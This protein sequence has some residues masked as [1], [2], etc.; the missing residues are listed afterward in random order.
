MTDDRRRSGRARSAVAFA[1]VLRGAG[2]TCRI[3]AV[4]AFA[5]ALAARRARHA[6]TPCTGPAGRRSCAAR[7]RPDSTTARSP[8]SGS[9]EHDRATPSPTGVEAAAP[10]AR[11]RRRRRRRTMT[12]GETTDEP[13]ASPVR[14]SAARGAAPQGLRGLHARRVRRGPPADGRPAAGRRAPALPSRRKRRVGADRGRPDLRRTVRRALRAGRRADPP[15]VR[16]AGERGRAG[17]CCCST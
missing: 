17:S 16:R 12:T 3:G 9:S 7:G 8:R 6:A 11:R 2:S 4:L 13:D 10:R 15:R 1:R 5:E 14:F